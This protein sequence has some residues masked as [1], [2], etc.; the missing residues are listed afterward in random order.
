M[1]RKTQLF[2]NKDQDAKFITFDNYTESLTGDILVTN[3]KL[4]PSRF[5]CAYIENLDK[6]EFIKEYLESWYE[7]KLAFLRDNLDKSDDIKNL[8]PLGYLVEVISAYANKGNE[9][10]DDHNDEEETSEINTDMFTFIGNI[11]EMDY[12]GTYTDII[13]TISPTGKQKPKFIQ[14]DITDDISFDYN[15]KAEKD[16]ENQENNSPYILYGWRN[17]YNGE[18][19]NIKTYLERPVKFDEDNKYNHGSKIQSF[20][21]DPADESVK[22]NII[23]PLFDLQ[24]ID[25]IHNSSDLTDEIILNNEHNIPL[26]VYF[27][28]E[29]VELKNDENYSPNWSLMISMQFSAFPYSYEIVKGFNDSDAIKDAYLTFAQILAKQSNTLD[30]LNKYNEMIASLKTKINLLES[31]FSNIATTSTIDELTTSMNNLNKTVDT[32]LAEYNERL[33]ELQEFIE[34]TRIK[35]TIKNN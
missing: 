18:S 33:N 10:T 31:M 32:K 21:F 13:C 22:F 1:N 26:G 14:E 16:E 12:N 34:A 25:E 27:C 6:E 29:P 8:N 19:Q 11:V 2:Y 35:W 5:L 20:D 17:E 30:L 9:E 15:Y 28:D 3:A 4:Y 23:I 24:Y 7:N